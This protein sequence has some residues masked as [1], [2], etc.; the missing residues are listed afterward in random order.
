MGGRGQA[1]AAPRRHRPPDR[2]D[3]SQQVIEGILRIPL[4]THEDE[5]G[6]FCELRRDSC[7]LS[8]CARPTRLLPSRSHPRAALPRARPE[9]PLRLPQRHGARRRPRPRERRDVHRGH[10]RRQPGRDLHP[11]PPRARLRG[12]DGRPPLLPRD[13]RVRPRRPR[14]AQRPLERPARRAPVEHEH[15]DPVRAGRRRRVLITGAGGQLGRALGAAFAYDDVVALTPRGLGRRQP[16]SYMCHKAASTSSCT[17]PPGRTW[18]ARSPIRRAPPRSTSA[19]RRTSPCSARPA[20]HLLDR[21]RLRR[22]QALAVRRVRRAE[23]AVRVR[24]HEAPRRGRGRP[25]AWIVRSSWLFGPTGHNFVRTMLRLA[26]EHDEVAVV[27]DQRGLPDVRRPPGGRSTRARG[28]RLSARASGTSPPTATA[29]GPTSRRRSSRRRARD[30]GAA[31]LDRRARPPRPRP[32]YS[33]LRS[34]RRA[35]RVLP[36]WRDGLRACLAELRD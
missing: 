25:D 4:A 2:G 7:C 10:R 18:T 5:R 16:P 33:V 14:R 27:D 9:R 1:L 19:A 30:A 17:L 6:W 32:A 21:L 28:R 12:A 34:E 3:R 36:H 20:R 8:R 11:R 15:P 23:P 26:A 35:R 31:D 29:P 24:P 22:A 13:R